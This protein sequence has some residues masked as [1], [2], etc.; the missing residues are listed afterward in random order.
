MSCPAEN[1]LASQ[2]CKMRI[3]HVCEWEGQFSARA[4]GSPCYLTAN[5]AS[6][7]ADSALCVSPT[8]QLVVLIQ[9]LYFQLF[10]VHR[11]LNWDFEDEFSLEV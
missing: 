1:L 5:S 6:L 8:P 3:A 10:S 9:S 4:G 2:N 11:Y 7:T